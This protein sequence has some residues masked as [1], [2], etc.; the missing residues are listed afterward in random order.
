MRND[1]D[2]G[3]VKAH[4]VRLHLRLLTKYAVSQQRIPCIGVVGGALRMREL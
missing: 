3:F 1:S 2:V 4:E